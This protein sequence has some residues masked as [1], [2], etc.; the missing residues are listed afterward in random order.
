MPLSSTLADFRKTDEKLVLPRAHSADQAA[1]KYVA[2]RQQ[3]LQNYLS[4]LHPVRQ[5]FMRF[6]RKWSW[7]NTEKSIYPFQTQAE[8][9]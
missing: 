1:L 6:E 5:Q 2:S 8:Q 9:C 3:H 7:G 4:K